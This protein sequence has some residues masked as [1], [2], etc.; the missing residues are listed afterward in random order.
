MVHGHRLFL[1]VDPRSVW[2]RHPLTISCSIY[3]N[4]GLLVRSLS[5]QVCPEM[6]VFHV[7]FGRILALCVKVRVDGFF[8]GVEGFCPI[9]FSPVLFLMRNLSRLSLFLQLPLGFSLYRAF[10]QFM[11]MGP[12]WFSLCF[13]CL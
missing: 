8:S 3:C 4:A 12:V 10:E 7:R 5:P 6:P 9:L 1:C 2:C 13:L 11:T